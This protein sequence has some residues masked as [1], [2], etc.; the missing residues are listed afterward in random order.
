MTNEEKIKKLK[1][2]LEEVTETDDSVCYVTSDDTDALKAAIKALEQQPN[3][4]DSCTH[5]EEQDGSNCYECVKGMADNFEAQQTDE[6]CI[7]REDA[8]NTA[9]EA[10]DEWDGGCNTNRATMIC[11][12]I[13]NLPSVTPSRPK[14][15]W[16]PINPL[17]EDDGGAY[18][19]S[20][21]EQGD[22]D[23]DIIYKY[24]PFCGADMRESEVEE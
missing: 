1:D 19:C 23:C 8:I 18:I 7:S 3:Q 22:W 10:V 17:Q 13:K 6:D 4:C 9:I 2:I 21:C 11:K 20:N 24:C 12:A 14:G 15:K 16:I 5:S